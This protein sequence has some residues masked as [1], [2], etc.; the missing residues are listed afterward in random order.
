MG[1]G[2]RRGAGGGQRRTGRGAQQRAEGEGGGEP[3]KPGRGDWQL[4]FRCMSRSGTRGR[5]DRRWVRTAAGA[6]PRPPQRCH[7]H[8][9]GAG[10][11][12]C[13]QVR[14][15]NGV[16]SRDHST[17]RQACPE[18]ATVL[19]ATPPWAPRPAHLLP[20][21]ARPGWRC[22]FCGPRGEASEQ[23]PGDRAPRKRMRVRGSPAATPLLAENRW[24]R[25]CQ[26]QPHVT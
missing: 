1:P 8:C 20:G 10:E 9:E 19:P 7:L 13:P 12:R 21:E 5:W 25:R 3:R 15:S 2:T 23:P 11:K 16:V 4:A 24:G 14:H 6:G 17:Q 22:R 26:L 18:S